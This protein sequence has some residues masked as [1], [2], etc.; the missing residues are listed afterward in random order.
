MRTLA[1]SNDILYVFFQIENILTNQDQFSLESVENILE[2]ENFF[3]KSLHGNSLMLGDDVEP[4]LQ[5]SGESDSLI[6][7]R[8]GTGLDDPYLRTVPEGTDD[9]DR[10]HHLLKWGKEKR[11]RHCHNLSKYQIGGNRSIGRGGSRIS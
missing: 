9:M 10:Q 3:L 11:R 2:I 8:T 4:E 5:P 6:R 1:F 7:E